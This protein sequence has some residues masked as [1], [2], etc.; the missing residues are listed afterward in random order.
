VSD[1]V[2]REEAE[3]TQQGDVVVGEGS[4]SQDLVGAGADRIEGTGMDDA[5]VES[6]A[7]RDTLLDETTGDESG[8]PRRT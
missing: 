7:T 8:Y 3:V 4:R 6:G 1:T 5:T 2:R